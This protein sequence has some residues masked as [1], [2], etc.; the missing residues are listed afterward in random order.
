MWLA[1]L[2]AFQ[3]APVSIY[4]VGWLACWFSLRTG[5]AGADAFCW[6]GVGSGGGGVGGWGAQIVC[7]DFICWSFDP[8]ILNNH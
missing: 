1:P 7:L 5:E 8:V 2:L 6:D 3:S 4:N